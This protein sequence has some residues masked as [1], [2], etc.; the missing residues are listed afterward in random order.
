MQITI[1]T[2]YPIPI[3]INLKYLN[4]LFL[5]CTNFELFSIKYSRMEATIVYI[6]TTLVPRETWLHLMVSEFRSDFLNLN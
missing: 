4:L 5:K 2:S 6:A 1:T 3:N